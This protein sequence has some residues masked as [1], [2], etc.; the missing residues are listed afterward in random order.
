VKIKPFGSRVFVELQ[1]I[2]QRKVGSIIIPDKHSEPSRVGVI[3]EI[4]P[5]VKNVKVGDKIVISYHAGTGIDFI[6][7]GYHYD[8]HRFLEESDLL[9]SYEE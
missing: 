5:E 2:E 9:G 3:L 4:G 7:S 8:Q 1:A 6:G